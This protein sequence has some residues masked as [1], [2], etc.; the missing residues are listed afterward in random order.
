ML[1]DAQIER[2]A[3]QIVLP[4][5]GGR[6]QERL[7]AST[8]RLLA[9]PGAEEALET[10]LLC[11]IHLGVAGVGTLV[12]DADTTGPVAA[13][14]G[15]RNPD[16]RIVA[17]ADRADAS[18]VIGD[19][20]E[21]DRR[22]A[23]VLGTGNAEA[24]LVA[25]PRGRCAACLRVAFAHLGTP[26]EWPK[27]AVPLLASLLATATLGEILELRNA[28]PTMLVVGIR[29]AAAASRAID[30]RPGCRAC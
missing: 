27:A 24:L 8:V 25:V 12:L 6:G 20:I 30:R 14:V 4:E 2:F 7:L 3:R 10:L 5:V 23:T 1:S 22:A 21:H 19:T 15:V 29:N 16:V 18:I 26:G 13:A 17:R 11:A 9:E 28:E